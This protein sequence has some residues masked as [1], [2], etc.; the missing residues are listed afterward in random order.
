MRADQSSVA[1]VSVSR[2]TYAALEI[3]SAL[4]I[5]WNQKIN[6]VSASTIADLWSRHIVDSAQVFKICPNVQGVWADLGSGGGFPGLVIA[7]LARELRPELKVVLVESDQRKSA[8]LSTVIRETGVSAIVETQRIETLTPLAADIISARA[9]AELPQLLTFATRHLHPKGIALFQKGAS[10][11]KELAHARKSWSF[12][13]DHFTSVTA[14]EAVILKI[15]RIK[16][17]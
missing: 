10:W 6:L 12:T 3:Y 9:L 4:L 15:G 17:G 14:P 16:R 13:S 2:E 8:F 5:K 1:K 7:I 11:Q